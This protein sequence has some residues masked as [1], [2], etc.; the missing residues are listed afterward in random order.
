YLFFYYV[1]S[2]V[3]GTG[4]GYLYSHFGWFGIVG[5]IGVYAIAGF[6]LCRF[7]LNGRARR[8]SGTP[9]Y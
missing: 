9:I 8:E 7:L 5:M 6:A 3:S 4:G 2:S 1:G